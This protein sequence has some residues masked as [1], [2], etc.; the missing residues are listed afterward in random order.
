M[1][2]QVRT[3]QEKVAQAKN[4]LVL[5]YPFFGNLILR[6][7]TTEDYEC[8]SSWTDGVSFG[9]NPEYI[10]SL[11]VEEVQ[12]ILAKAVLKL[13]LGHTTRRG[14]R[15]YELW[16]LASEY[17]TNPIVMESGKNKISL[18]QPVLFRND[19]KG[20]SVEDAYKKLQK[21]QQESKNKNGKKTEGDQETD[22]EKE[23]RQG[24]ENSEKEQQTEQQTDVE[25]KDAKDKEGNKLT[26]GEKNKEEQKWRINIQQSYEI[27][28][29]I[30]DIPAGLERFVVKLLNPKLGYELLRVFM[31]IISR[32]DYYW[33]IPNKRYIALNT[34][35]PSLKSEDLPP[36][37][38]AIDSSGSISE[39][40]LTRFLSEVEYILTIYKTTVYLVLCDC[41]V[42]K[43]Y[44]LTQDDLPLQL[45]RNIKLYG[46]G[47]TDFRP[48]FEWVEKE[49]ITPSV[50]LYYTD[51]ECHDFPSQE[52]DYPVIWIKEGEYNNKPPFGDLIELGTE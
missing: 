18:P 16:Q 52:P 8:N 50:F 25:V 6:L 17:V 31:E 43:V 24:G 37:V 19:L 12:G 1:F 44:E 47:G 2:S 4:Y 32:D 9:Y 51:M 3:P 39:P 7:E 27:A 38:A 28:K 29:S 21:E 35:L 13:G 26:G 11:S 5:S 36:V 30:G 46:Y 10:N 40:A 33:A 45:N 42:H 22:E 48:P 41:R 15:N 49:G 23:E 14:D 34:Y 20:L